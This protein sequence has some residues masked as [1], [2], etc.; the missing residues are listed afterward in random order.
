MTAH[1]GG[2][3]W[4]LRGSDPGAAGLGDAELLK[5]LRGGER[6]RAFTA[7]VRRHG[8]LVLGVCRRVL[9]G[10]HDADDAFQA[11]FLILARRAASIRKSASLAAW[12]HGVAL[13]VAQRMKT[14]AARRREVEA[15]AA[16]ARGE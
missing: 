3:V 5:Q 9:P 1:V 7:L 6:E 10:C 8:P 11:T 15:R 13:R 4:W 16:A 2:L 14:D 12:L